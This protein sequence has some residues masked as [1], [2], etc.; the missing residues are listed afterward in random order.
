ML[1]YEII[2]IILMLIGSIFLFLGAL[3]VFRM[4]NVYNRMQAGTKAST[5][6]ALAF[7]IGVGVYHPV[8]FV[9]SAL[10]ALFLI[11]TN[12]VGSNVMSRAAHH[13][14]VKLT[15]K[16][17]IDKYEEDIEEILKEEEY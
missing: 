16:S 17:V 2:G 10:I 5:L 4:P 12:P 13:S 14:G 15:E 1:W 7:I 11:L 8:W 9:K 6:G 3:G